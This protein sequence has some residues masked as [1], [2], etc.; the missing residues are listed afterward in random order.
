[1]STTM[2]TKLKQFLNVQTNLVYPDIGVTPT[3]YMVW[4]PVHHYW[5]YPSNFNSEWISLSN[6]EK[7]FLLK[8]EVVMVTLRSDEPKKIA[9]FLKDY[10]RDKNRKLHKK[11]KR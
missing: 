4:S 1:M 7:K 3:M 2:K 5:F 8:Q 9:L 11:L 10:G 6:K